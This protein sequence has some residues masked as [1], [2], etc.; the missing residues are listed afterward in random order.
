MYAVS[1]VVYRNFSATG[2]QRGM[3]AKYARSSEQCWL[4]TRGGRFE[5]C[6]RRMR[7]EYVFVL[8]TWRVKKDDEHPAQQ[9]KKS[10]CMRWANVCLCVDVE[11]AWRVLLVFRSGSVDGWRLTLARTCAHAR[12]L[13]C[14]RRTPPA[15]TI[16][17]NAENGRRKQTGEKRT[18][19]SRMKCGVGT[20]GPFVG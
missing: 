16:W 8:S 11:R 5:L 2:W 12:Q 17:G 18:R 15:L 13:C 6:G 9:R 1:C 14:G 20:T 4:L 19:E 7:Y 3:D 10:E